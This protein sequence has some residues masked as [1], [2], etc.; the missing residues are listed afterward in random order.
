M[1][2]M[3]KNITFVYDGIKRKHSINITELNIQDVA[4]FYNI[5]YLTYDL[6]AHY[7]DEKLYKYLPDGKNTKINTYYY[8]KLK[9]NWH[10]QNKLTPV[11]VEAI[12]ENAEFVNMENVNIIKHFSFP[13]IETLN[14]GKFA[15]D[16]SRDFG[17]MHDGLKENVEFYT[18]LHIFPLRLYSF[19]GAFIMSPEESNELINVITAINK[20]SK[21][22]YDELFKEAIKEMDYLS[23]EPKDLNGIDD[24][25]KWDN[26]LN[27]KIEN[28]QP[29]QQ[30]QPSQPIS[31]DAE[32][33]KKLYEKIKLENDEL[34]DK[35]EMLEEENRKLNNELKD[36]SF[37]YVVLQC[38][39]KPMLKNCKECL[40][41]F[42]KDFNELTNTAI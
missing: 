8:Y 33:W 35:N 20:Y 16:K 34:F 21:N 24:F 28:G 15:P 2:K 31:E 25:F 18:L 42:E 32:K 36:T 14:F 22:D 37:K 40:E 10:I 19:D 9:F 4:E 11:Y 30:K 13:C 38:K 6:V 17:D 23:S 26:P 7:I 1:L 3:D 12:S 39:I 5:S 41:E 29:S 27:I